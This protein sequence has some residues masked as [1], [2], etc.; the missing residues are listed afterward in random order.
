MTLVKSLNFSL[1]HFPPHLNGN[2]SSTDLI[3]LIRVN[4]CK[5][6]RTEPDIPS[7]LL[8]MGEQLTKGSAPAPATHGLLEGHTA[9]VLAGP[10]PDSDTSFPHDCQMGSQMGSQ[11]KE[12]ITLNQ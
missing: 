3:G 6:L 2:S 5:T 8:L 10:S 7:K 11:T 9:L 12:S 4:A 1:P